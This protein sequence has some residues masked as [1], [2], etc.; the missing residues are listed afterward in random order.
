MN[1]LAYLSKT[2]PVNLAFADP[3]TEEYVLLDLASTD[4][5]DDYIRD[6][7]MWAIKLGV[8]VYCRAEAIRYYDPSL[9]KNCA[10]K[11]SSGDLVCNLDGDNFADAEFASY[12]RKSFDQLQ[13]NALLY[14][15]L[16]DRSGRIAVWRVILDSL[17]GYDEDLRGYG[18]EDVDLRE[19]LTRM[20][21]PILFGDPSR[22]HSILNPDKTIGC[23]AI[24]DIQKTDGINRGK[25]ME[26]ARAGKVEANQGKSWGKIIV[27]QNFRDY[28]ETE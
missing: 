23:Y 12:L 16:T 18:S 20:G 21:G 25:S 1:W 28:V 17:G 26:N 3:E 10:I 4:G 2:L 15:G 14:P 19:R 6:K 7:F 13:I 27:K 11:L 5:T 24:K 22:Y 9:A 8:L